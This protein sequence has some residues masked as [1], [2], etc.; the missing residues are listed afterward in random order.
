MSALRAMSNRAAVNGPLATICG[1]DC[2]FVKP[3]VFNH[4]AWLLRQCVGAVAV[5]ASMAMGATIAVAQI[6]AAPQEGVAADASAGA[7]GDGEASFDAFLGEASADVEQGVGAA[8]GATA[9]NLL[10][11]LFSAA[12][13]G[14][15]DRHMPY[16]LHRLEQA[17]SSQNLI[18]F[19]ELVDSRYFAERFGEIAATA[20]SPGAAMRQFSCEFFTLCDVSKKYGYGDVVSAKVLSVEPAGDYVAVRIEMRMWDGLFLPAEVFYDPKNARLIAG[21]S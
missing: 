9:D 8:S 20:P 6:T 5:V 12:R 13:R 7:H 3:R 15:G 17:M 14:E 1:N 19:L 2:R 11:S 18:G 10:P 21:F 16:V 4:R